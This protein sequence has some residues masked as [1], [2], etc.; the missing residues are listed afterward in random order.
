MCARKGRR[1]AGAPRGWVARA[2]SSSMRAAFRLR[3][4]DRASSSGLLACSI[5]TKR[6]PPGTSSRRRSFLRSR[7][8]KLVELALRPS[9][10]AQESKPRQREERA[11]AADSVA[12]GSTAGPFL[13]R[14]HGPAGHRI[15]RANQESVMRRTSRASRV[16]SSGFESRPVTA[17]T[18][19]RARSHQRHADRLQLQPPPVQRP[20]FRNSLGAPEV[21]ANAAVL[22]ARLELGEHHLRRG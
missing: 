18:R 3:S 4:G 17:T 16:V 20:V 21:G 1:G 22:L 15:G 12:H 13:R 14:D 19:S 5:R 9:I 8:T 7:R 2:H 10:P 6:A 11:E